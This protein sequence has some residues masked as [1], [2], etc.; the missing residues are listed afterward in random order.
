MVKQEKLKAG[1][2]IVILLCLPFLFGF[3][4]AQAIRAIIGE[5]SNQG[6]NGML[7]I[8]VGIRNRGSL[9]GVYGLTA[10]HV[11]N[12]PIWV[13]K[14]ALQAWKDSKLNRIHSGTHWENIKR[15]GKPS[16]I[17]DMRLVYKYKE[18]NFYVKK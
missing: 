11:D 1:L 7:A 4:D 12:E 3:T 2:T 10:K 6:Y 5:A 16:W 14:L 8:A 13:W 18:H 9:K 17:K 15:F